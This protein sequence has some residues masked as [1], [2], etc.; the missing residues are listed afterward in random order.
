M[1]CAQARLSLSS[2][3]LTQMLAAHTHSRHARTTSPH[4]VGSRTSLGCGAPG[5][6]R[7]ALPLTSNATRSTTSLCH[8]RA[9]VRC[10]HSDPAR[11]L[12]GTAL[13]RAS[14]VVCRC[15]QS[16][17]RCTRTQN[18]NARTHIARTH[19]S[20]VKLVLSSTPSCDTSAAFCALFSYT[21]ISRALSR[22]IITQDVRDDV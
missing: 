7:L 2:A 11:R 12:P 18:V 13:M 9:C 17:G 19:L 4:D 15:V 16:G 1:A 20:T 6:T 21:S 5:S 3:P 10:A 22:H 14:R 8:V